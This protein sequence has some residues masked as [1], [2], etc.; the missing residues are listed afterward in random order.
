MG[1]YPPGVHIH[2]NTSLH[3]FRLPELHNKLHQSNLG[4]I[5]LASIMDELNIMG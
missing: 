2:K 1:N 4:Q 5:K 3:M